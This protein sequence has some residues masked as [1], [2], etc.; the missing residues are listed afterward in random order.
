MQF[1]CENDKI[2][3]AAKRMGSMLCAGGPNVKCSSAKT[4][5]SQCDVNCF[6]G[7]EKLRDVSCILGRG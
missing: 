4:C 7:R 2:A 1:D 3:C 6:L 5:T